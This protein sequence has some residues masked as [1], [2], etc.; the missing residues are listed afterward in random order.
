M[1]IAISTVGKEVSPHFGRCPF[2]TLVDIENGRTVNR[3]EIGN[4]GHSPGFIPEFL[5]KKGVRKIVC[6]GMGL[7]AQGFFEEFGIEAIAGIT[8]RVDD[9][10]EKLEQGSLEGSE[11]LCNPGG[12]KGYGIDK[13]E[14]DHTHK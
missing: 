2:F 14:C 3:T 5:Y 9:V 6:G 7:R 13:T 1:I 12:G 10:I 11:S 4:P 8:G